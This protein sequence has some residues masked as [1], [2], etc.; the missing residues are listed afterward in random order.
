[1]RLRRVEAERY[2]ALAGASLGDLG[3]ALTI[4]H[5]PNEAGKSSF[6]ALVRHVLYR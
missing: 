5:G 3:D 4:V 2:G 6:T 1:M